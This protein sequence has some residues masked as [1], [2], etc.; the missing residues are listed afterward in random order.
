M[1]T[2]N[3]TVKEALSQIRSCR[4]Q[5]RPNPGFISQLVMYEQMGTTLDPKHKRFKL[6]QMIAAGNVMKKGKSTCKA[7]A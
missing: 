5:I 4:K 6:L 3:L 7:V 2:N 1:K